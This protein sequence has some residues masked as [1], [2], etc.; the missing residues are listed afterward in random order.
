MTPDS[1]AYDRPRPIAFE[2]FRDEHAAV[3]RIT[4][5]YDRHTSFL[6]ERFAELLQ[7]KHLRRRVRATYP[8]VRVETS[9]FAKVDSR[10]AYGHVAAPGVYSTTVTRPALFRN[11]LTEQIRLLMRHHGLPVEVGPSAEPIPLHFAFDDAIHIEGEIADTVARPLRDMFDVPDL[12]VIDDA[13]VNGTYLPPLGG[14]L[15]L[16]PFTASPVDY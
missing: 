7:H 11:Y 13:I 8:E 1:T 15:A 6:R 4:E 5:I 14:A 16:A 2:A 12:A 9:S 10:L 3:A